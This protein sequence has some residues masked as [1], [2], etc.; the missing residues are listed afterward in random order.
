MAKSRH[1]PAGH[2]SVRLSFK[3]T[4]HRAPCLHEDTTRVAPPRSASCS[5]RNMATGKTSEH[6][7]TPM[8]HCDDCRFGEMREERQTAVL[9]CAHGHKPPFVLPSSP[10]CEDWGWMRR[11][12]DFEAVPK[13]SFT[14]PPK[15]PDLLHEQSKWREAGERSSVQQLST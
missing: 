5:I 12:K 7:R 10:V 9:L 6:G 11:C 1:A 3:P 14:K 15:S 2:R 4:F 13:G 8:K